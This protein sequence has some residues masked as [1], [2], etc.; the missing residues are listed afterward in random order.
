M[1]DITSVL[2]TGSE[3]PGLRAGK[4]YSWTEFVGQSA[5]AAGY[6]NSGYCKVW[7]IV[8]FADGSSKKV[9]FDLSRNRSL[10]DDLWPVR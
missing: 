1:K 7:T 4:T 10:L 2:V 3:Y 9:R 5:G 6:F 8:Y